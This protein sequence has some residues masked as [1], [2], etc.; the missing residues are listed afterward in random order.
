[1]PTRRSTSSSRAGIETLKSSARLR[2]PSVMTAPTPVRLPRP[3][4]RSTSRTR[5]HSV[6]TWRAR[7]RSTGSDSTLRSPSSHRPRG[8]PMRFAARLAL[9][10]AVGVARRR[11]A[12]GRSRSAPRR[13][14]PL[15]GWRPD[16]TPGV[17]KSM[18][19]AW[20]AWAPRMAKGSSSPTRDPAASSA[21][22]QSLASASGS[23]VAAQRQQGGHREG[24]ARR[25][26]GADRNGA[27][28]P[29]G[30]ARRRVGQGDEGGRQCGLRPVRGR[31]RPEGSPTARGTGRWPRRSGS[32]PPWG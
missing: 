8:R 2:C 3:K 24:G 30:T 29:Q 9:G 32:C 15:R 6:M 14:P 20:P 25:E 26:A 23:P 5:S 18:K 17:A 21:L 4:R 22:W 11:P 12:R 7:R 19:R 27:G 16:E 13:T 1:M 28:D 10:P 31:C